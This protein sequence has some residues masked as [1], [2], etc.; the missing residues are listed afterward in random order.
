MARSSNSQSRLASPALSAKSG[1]AAG[2]GS[3]VTPT[4]PRRKPT[5]AED[6]WMEGLGMFKDDPTFV[7]M[8]KEIYKDRSGVYDE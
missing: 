1:S 8:M 5:K 4:P 6:P 7:P 3:S 2:G